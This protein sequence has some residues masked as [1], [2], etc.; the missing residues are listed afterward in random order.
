VSI[1]HCKSGGFAHR[2]LQ[3]PAH[4]VPLDGV[5]VLFGNGEADTW[6]LIGLLAVENFKEKGSPAACFAFPNS[7]KLRPAFQ[8]PDSV[9]LVFTRRHCPVRA[10]RPLGRQTGTAACATSR[11]NLA[12]TLGSHAGTETMTTLANKLGRLVGTLHFFNA[13]VCGPS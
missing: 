1:F 6:R 2:F 5:S 9:F 11:K 3:A 4:P 13:A 12:A 8:P 7:K 10:S